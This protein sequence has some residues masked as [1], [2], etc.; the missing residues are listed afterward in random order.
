MASKRKLRRRLAKLYVD[1]KVDDLYQ[2]I[3][4][5]SSSAQDRLEQLRREVFDQF[6]ELARSSK[7][8]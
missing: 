4:D 5:N 2:A 1:R 7:S 6:D 8:K 3:S